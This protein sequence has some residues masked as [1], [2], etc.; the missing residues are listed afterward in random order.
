M[1]VG[2][3]LVHVGYLP[4][5]PLL[6]GLVKR[7]TPREHAI[8]ICNVIHLPLRQRLVESGAAVEHLT[9]VFD[10][11]E[12]R[13]IHLIGKDHV[14]A[15]VEH[16]HCCSPFYIA[17]LLDRSERLG[18]PLCAISRHHLHILHPLGPYLYGVKPIFCRSK[19]GSCLY[20]GYR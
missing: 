19:G 10:P 14:F 7:V 17:K 8:H 6:E 15:V 12:L 5:V 4:R 1:A 11:V 18:A 9:H 16:P 2:K 3:H 13:A 20:V